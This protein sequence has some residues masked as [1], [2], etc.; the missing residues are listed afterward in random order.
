M[1]RDLNDLLVKLKGNSVRV[2][3]TDAYPEAGKATTQLVFSEGT[4]LRI[5]YWRAMGDGKERVSSFD[6]RQQYGLPAP[7]DAILELRGQLQGQIVT[8]AHLDSETGDLLIQF[9]DK[10]KLQVFGFSAYEVWE[11][12]LPDG[13]TEY[14]NHSK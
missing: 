6:H 10:M 3:N 8:G 12:S 4:K 14:S 9:T 13:G 7:I 11:L 2:L 5:D 1:P